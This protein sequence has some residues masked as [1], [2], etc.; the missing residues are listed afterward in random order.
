[1][2]ELVCVLS[3]PWFQS[4]SSLSISSEEADVASWQ[5]P[6]RSEMMYV[7]GVPCEGANLHFENAFST[8]TTDYRLVWYK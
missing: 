8:R 5:G 3:S 1:M 4:A 7:V 6:A 2:A